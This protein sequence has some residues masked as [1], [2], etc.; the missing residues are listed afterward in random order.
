MG[1]NTL[2]YVRANMKE[3]PIAQ[4]REIT[5]KLG[6]NYGPTLSI[7]KEIW[8]RNNEGPYLL[9]ISE[10]LAIQREAESYLIHPSMLDACLQS[11]FIPLRSLLTDD[12]SIVLVGFQSITF[13]D[14]PSTTQLYCHV[15]SIVAE[16]GRFD[17]TIR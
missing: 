8:Q 5:E 13:N 10:S 9:D 16:Y 2:K 11:C 6:F 1:R 7:I 4:F 17:V 15:I 3:M 12:K 14:V